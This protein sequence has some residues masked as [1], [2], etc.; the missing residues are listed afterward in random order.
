[1]WVA[2]SIQFDRPPSPPGIGSLPTIRMPVTLMPLSLV[3]TR[4]SLDPGQLPV[5][6][7]L[8]RVSYVQ[9]GSLGWEAT[10]ASAQPG[11]RVRGGR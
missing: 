6:I 5:S 7:A 11:C 4:S 8:P 10:Q 2:K 9:P 1:M 3:S